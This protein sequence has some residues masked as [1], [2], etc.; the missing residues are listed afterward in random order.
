MRKPRWLGRPH[1]RAEASG[2]RR[3]WVVPRLTTAYFALVFVV[4]TCVEPYLAPVNNPNENTRTYLTMAIVEQHTFHL[5]KIVARQGWVGDLGR[6]AEHPVPPTAAGAVKPPKI[7]HAPVRGSGIFDPRLGGIA[8]DEKFYM[9]VKAPAMSYAGVPFYWA[10]TKIAPRFGHRVPTDAA[11]PV[12]RAWWLRA[13]TFTLRFFTVQLPCFAFLVWF[14]RWLRRTTD[15]SVLRLSA[16]S[17]VAFGSNFLAYALM[18]VSHATCAIAAF[19]AFGITLAARLDSQGDVRRRRS[20]TAFSVGLLIGLVPLLE[21]TAVPV[22]IFLG[23]YALFTFWRPRQ[24]FAFAFAGGLSVA[25]LQTKTFGFGKPSG[26]FLKDASLSHSSGFFG[27]SPFMWLGLLAIPF[28]LFAT[29]GT[30]FER[31]ERRIATAVWIVAMISLWVF[32]SSASNPHGGWSIGP[33]YLGAAPPFFAFG[34]ALALE[35]ISRR[36]RKWRVVSRAAAG[37]LAIASAAQVGFVSMVYNTVTETTAR[38][39]AR[40]ALPLAWA[41]Y[42]PHHAGELVGW[43]S[44]AFWYFAAGCLFAGAVLAATWPARDTPWSWT[45]RFVGVIGFATIGLLPAFAPLDPKDPNDVHFPAYL[46]SIWEP[47]GRDRLT[48]TRIEAERENSARPCLWYRVADYELGLGMAVE[49]ARDAKRATIP[50]ERCR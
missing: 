47:P 12:E 6:A 9:S 38:P 27:M 32:V 13:A 31:R 23:L 34:A 30:R 21:Y 8:M 48:K 5:D 24:L 11:T 20:S 44:P 10:F 26:A 46:A 4:F 17:A 7:E 36:G 50:R 19:M 33:R 40:F 41:G 43:A 29:F 49:A 42:V 22:A 45:L 39:L 37:G 14:E 28:A 18:F 1:L 16:V 25:G 2:A 15:D 3:S 35:R